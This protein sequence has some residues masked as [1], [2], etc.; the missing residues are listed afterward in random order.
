MQV[1]EA[2]RQSA[3]HYNNPTPEMGFGIPDLMMA[4]NILTV[5]ESHVADAIGL[6]LFP[7]PFRDALMVGIEN[8]PQGSGAILLVIDAAGRVVL[9][10]EVRDGQVVINDLSGI[11]PG[12]YTVC[13]ETGKR[14]VTRKLLK[15]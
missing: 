2:A 3:S 10:K 11:A 7:N 4:N 15:Y 1:L 12:Y 8:A 6:S 5:I 13:V 14:Q 9:K